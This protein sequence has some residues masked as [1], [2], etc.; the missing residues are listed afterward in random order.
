MNTEE[1]LKKIID[2]QQIIIY[3]QTE[4]MKTRS[5]LDEMKQIQ[6]EIEEKLERYQS[7]EKEMNELHELKQLLQN[8]TVLQKEKELLKYH[9]F[10]NSQ[11]FHES[12]K[13]YL[14]VL[15]QLRGWSNRENFSIIYD[16]D[17]DETTQYVVQRLILCRP[18]IYIFL[19]DTKGNV[20][21]CFNR[22]ST[23]KILT[24]MEDTNHFIFRLIS[25]GIYDQP[26]KWEQKQTSGNGC[27][28]LNSENNES[29]RLFE[30]GNQT[31]F[32]AVAIPD[33]KK[34]GC[35]NLS[36]KYNQMNNDDLNETNNEVF[37][38]ERIL[39]VQME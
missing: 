34:S 23:R 28:F 26:M 15:Q 19:F 36:D 30:I 33:I 27:F 7:I 1:L 31:S 5:E 11:E 12:E 17:K 22:K 16:S 39:I 4:L 9:Q 25:N 21:G 3:T 37:V 20:F 18:S 14:K 10:I 38:I 35:V 13:N 6:T 8:S 2:L 24:R 29:R 32:L